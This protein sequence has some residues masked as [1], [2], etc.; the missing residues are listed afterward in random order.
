MVGKILLRGMLVGIV[1]GLLAFGFA[2]VAGEPQVDRAIAFEDQLSQEKGETPEPEL[3]SREVQSTIGLLT[4]VVVFGTGVGGLFALVFAFAQGRVGHLRPRTIAA[5]LAGAAFLAVYLVPDLKYPANPPS[6]GAPETIG[7]RTGLYFFMVAFSIVAMGFA[8]TLGRRLAPRFGGWNASLI[9]GLAFVVVIGIVQAFLPD[10]NEV[11]AEFPAVVLWQF[12]V[13]S[14]G[15]QAVLWG[16][17]GL[18]FG[19]LTERSL[20]HGQAKPGKPA[21]AGHSA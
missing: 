3:V 4:G 2:K 19:F 15:I 1:A 5:L 7:Y 17:M 14:L 13:A 11:P 21:L 9:A 18:L 8:V 10:I 20:A 12:R 6:V 16:T